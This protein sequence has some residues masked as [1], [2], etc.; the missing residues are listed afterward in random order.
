METVKLLLADEK[1]D[2]NQGQ[3]VRVGGGR[4][5]C[6]VESGQAGRRRSMLSVGCVTAEG[7]TSSHQQGGGCVGWR[8]GHTI[9]QA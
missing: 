1:V 2:V 9:V 3:K 6:W 7:G 5:R 8:A 4:G